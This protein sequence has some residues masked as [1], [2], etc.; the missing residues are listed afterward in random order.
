MSSGQEVLQPT[1]VYQDGQVDWLYEQISRLS[2]IDRS[3]IV[4]LLDGFS[5][6][7]IA[8]IAGISENNVGVKIHRIK[9]QLAQA[10]K[11]RTHHGI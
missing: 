7:E 2:K 5:Y 3:L 11:T 4:L 1:E 8:G 6:R 9:K 10:S